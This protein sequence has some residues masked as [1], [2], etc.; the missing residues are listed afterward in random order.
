ML[1]ESPTSCV[2]YFFAIS[3]VDF[4]KYQ[5]LYRN[6]FTITLQFLKTISETRCLMA[7]TTLNNSVQ[8]SMPFYNKE[9]WWKTANYDEKLQNI[10]LV[11]FL[12]QSLQTK[13]MTIF[14]ALNIFLNFS[15]SVS[16]ETD[17]YQPCS[18]SCLKFP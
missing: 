12:W 1:T 11:D 5:K 9:T 14:F 6:A 17:D 16:D 18:E 13:K 8:E 3:H 7:L 15:S 10:L 4:Y 2:H